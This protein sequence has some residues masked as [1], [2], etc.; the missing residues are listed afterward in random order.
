MKWARPRSPGTLTDDQRREHYACPPHRVLSLR[1]RVGLA[2]GAGTLAL[3]GGAGIAY[4]ATST[5]DPVE[6]GWA[7]VVSGDDGRGAAAT[8]AD[9]S[10]QARSGA[11]CPDDEATGGSGGSGG[12]TADEAPQ[13]ASPS[14]DGDL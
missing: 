1:R 6:T 9:R 4:A 13:T 11:D 2:V 10:D 3:L 7:T 5:T 8:S 12:S 14:Q